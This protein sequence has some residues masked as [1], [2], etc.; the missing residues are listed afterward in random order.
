MNYAAGVGFYRKDGLIGFHFHNGLALTDLC[1]VFHQPI[2]Q[3]N[4]LDRLAEFGD[5]KLFRHQLTT[6]RQ[7]A[8]IRATLGMAPSSS[9]SARGTGTLAEAT[10][11][12]GA[13]R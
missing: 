10:R 8:M 1:T 6:F 7:A 4:F 13:S 9:I 5:E 11:T 2:D 3:G 12:I